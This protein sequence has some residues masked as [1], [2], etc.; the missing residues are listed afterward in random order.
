MITISL[1][2]KKSK[3]EM[4]LYS[5]LTL[6]Y[7]GDGVFEIM[8]RTYLAVEKSLPPDLLHKSAKD[9]VS[10]PA[11]SGMADKLQTFLNDEEIEIFK[12]GRNAK[13]KSHRKNL[14][15]EEYKK[16]T[17][18]E[19]LIGYLY[20]TGENERLSEIFKKILEIK[21]KAPKEKIEE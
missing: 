15:V 13:M 9:F 5:P 18:L 16:A 7:I 17:G 6:A 19:C 8:V 14:S 20:M 21:N 10:A 1:K 3:Q 12:R 2:K 11:Q 4:N